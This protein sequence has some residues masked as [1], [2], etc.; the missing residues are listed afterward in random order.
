VRLK[1][2]FVAV[3]DVH[4]RSHKNLLISLERRATSKD[5]QSDFSGHRG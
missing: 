2:A 5:A 1:V 4:E 3:F